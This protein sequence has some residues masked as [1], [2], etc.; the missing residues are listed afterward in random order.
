MLYEECFETFAFEK[1]IE[2]VA[3]HL[4]V[5]MKVGPQDGKKVTSSP[6]EIN[7]PGGVLSA[8]PIQRDDG[9][10]AF[11]SGQSL[12]ELHGQHHKKTTLFQQ[13]KMATDFTFKPLL[14]TTLPLRVDVAEGFKVDVDVQ[15]LLSWHEHPRA[16]KG[17]RVVELKAKLNEHRCRNPKPKM[18]LPRQRR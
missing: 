17:M 11:L 7:L 1:G 10:L 14:K 13:Q 16:R 6:I 15:R 4:K 9:V 3:L 12:I 8:Q 18:R 2:K 5:E